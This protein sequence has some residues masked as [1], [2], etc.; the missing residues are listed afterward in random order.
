MTREEAIKVLEEMS[1]WKYCEPEAEAAK[2]AISALREQCVRD[3]TKTSGEAV[4][5]SRQLETVTN[6]NGLNC[7]GIEAINRI[8]SDTVKGVEIDQFNWISVEERLPETCKETR[9][10][11]HSV[12]VLASENGRIMIGYFTTSKD[13]GSFDF[14]GVD[15][16]KKFY[17]FAKP[18]HWMPLPPMP[19]EE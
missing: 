15:S 1:L 12:T 16:H 11:Y 6:C 17:D 7:I 3:A 9:S 4:T 19:K 10:F 13:D 18:S 14:S 5:D 8:E 2:F